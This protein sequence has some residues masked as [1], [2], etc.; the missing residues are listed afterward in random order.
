MSCCC[1]FNGQRKACQRQAM[2]LG[3][4]HPCDAESPHQRQAEDFFRF[5]YF[6]AF[7]FKGWMEDEAGQ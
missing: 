4:N 1:S 2:L 5:W 7:F 6:Q 3:G